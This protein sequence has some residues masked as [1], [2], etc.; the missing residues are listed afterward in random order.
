VRGEYQFSPRLG[1]E[2]GVLG[3]GSVDV[4]SG[5]FAGTVGNAVQ[6]SSFTPFTVGL[7]VHLTPDHLLDVYAGPLLALVSYS[8]VDVQTTIG[9]ASTSVSVDNDVGLGAILGLDV[10]IGERGW[11]IQTN[12]RYVDTDIENSGG[13]IL[14]NSEFDPLIFSVGFGYRF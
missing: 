5:I 10:P 12:L 14:I 8:S 9:N 1:V 2:L 3:A 6:V 4:A 7:N 11:L 13:V